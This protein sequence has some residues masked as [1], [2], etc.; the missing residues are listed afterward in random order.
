MFQSG[1][2]IIIVTQCCIYLYYRKF[3]FQNKLL[4]LGVNYSGYNHGRNQ[5]SIQ[6][7][8]RLPFPPLSVFP[9]PSPFPLP[10][11]PLPS[12][13]LSH[14][15]SPPCPSPPLLLLQIGPTLPL[16]PLPLEVGPL[17]SSQG[18]GERCKLPQRGLGRSS[19]RNRIWCILALKS[20]SQWQQF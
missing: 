20:G 9:L 7:E 18:S 11:H 10:F 17:K 1:N 5:T 19:S 4:K 15:F 14:P 6:E 8:S 16:P 13:P 12:P 3:K 2:I